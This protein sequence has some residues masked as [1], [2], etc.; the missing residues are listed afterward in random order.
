VTISKFIRENA[1]MRG[2]RWENVVFAD[3]FPRS[4]KLPGTVRECSLC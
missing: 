4:I 1:P 2:K 3:N